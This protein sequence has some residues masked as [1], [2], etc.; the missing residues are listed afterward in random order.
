MLV[1]FI[2]ENTALLV[3]ILKVFP[4][5][6]L[7]RSVRHLHKTVARKLPGFLYTLEHLQNLR[8]THPGAQRPQAGYQ[9]CLQRPNDK[10][11]K[12]RLELE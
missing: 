11:V 12:F 4:E 7:V 3:A 8:V 2:V 5:R 9:R 1:V 10:D 6:G